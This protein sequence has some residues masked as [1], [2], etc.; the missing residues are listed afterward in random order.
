MDGGWRGDTLGAARLTTPAS[1]VARVHG[2]GFR[3]WREVYGSFDGDCVKKVRSTNE[4]QKIHLYEDSR[5]EHFITSRQSWTKS[6]KTRVRGRAYF[7]TKV[8]RAGPAEMHMSRP[9]LPNGTARYYI[10]P[11]PPHPDS[12]AGVSHHANVLTG[13]DVSICAR[14]QNPTYFFITAFSCDIDCG[15]A[16]PNAFCDVSAQSFR[17]IQ[18]YLL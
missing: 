14:A 7:D 16:D 9:S 12:Q 10:Q 18:F 17:D 3:K 11:P 2:A 1:T 6:G 13:I 8:S 4:M 5:T 15:E